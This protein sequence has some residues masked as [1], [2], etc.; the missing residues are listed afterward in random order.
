[1]WLFPED[2]VYINTPSGDVMVPR[3]G[4]YFSQAGAVSRG[5]LGAEPSPLKSYYDSQALEYPLRSY[6]DGEVL[7]SDYGKRQQARRGC[8]PSNNA[9]DSAARGG[10]RPGSR[11]RRAASGRS[12]YRSGPPQTRWENDCGCSVSAFCGA[13][14]VEGWRVVVSG[15]RGKQ[16]A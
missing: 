2:S 16:A 8:Q 7:E 5:F 10:T 11:Y 4:A 6:Y 9:V 12:F 15:S 3:N 13:C 1:M 14:H